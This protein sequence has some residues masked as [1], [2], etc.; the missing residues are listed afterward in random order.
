MRFLTFSPGFASKIFK[1]KDPDTG[2][3]YYA[4]DMHSLILH[5]ESYREQNELARIDNIYA[6]VNNYLC[7]LP[8]NRG[9]CSAAKIQR[10]FLGY[11][12][13]G[14]ALLKNMYYG[15]A[16]MVDT[17]TADARAELCL[18]CPNNVFPDKG[19][20]VQWSDEIAENSTYG[21]K[22]KHHDSLG[23]CSACSCPLRAKVFFKGPFELSKQEKEDIL[24]TKPDCWQIKS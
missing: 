9:A 4:P 13:G 23:N 15:E 5:I 19:Y 14:I 11:L 16:N 21:R 18:S 7:H 10:G 22:S 20:F 8:D 1:F 3:D 2:F 12:N 17:P 6:V 24:R